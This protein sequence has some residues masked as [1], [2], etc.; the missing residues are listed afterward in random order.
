MCA[1][2][3]PEGQPLEDFRLRLP[4]FSEFSFGYALTDNLIHGGLPKKLK[5]APTFPSL[6]KEGK[7]GGGYDVKVPLISAPL[8]LQFK[9]P[10]ILTRKSNKTPPG[11]GMPYYRMHVRPGGQSLQHQNLLNH[12][13]RHRLVY[14]VT[15]RFHNK[16]FLRRRMIEKSAFIRPSQIGSLDDRDHFVAYDRRHTVAWLYSEPHE[17]EG[18]IDS[19]TFIE[20]VEANIPEVR[21]AESESDLFESIAQEIIK[22]YEISVRET[23][24]RAR[25]EPSQ[26]RDSLSPTWQIGYD[27]PIEQIVGA[28]RDEAINQFVLAR[29]RYGSSGAAAYMAR[30]YLDCELI[31]VGKNY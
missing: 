25:D 22:T 19:E 13:R 20:E 30:F 1:D 3:G 24:A 18:S 16:V 8:F 5:A 6:Y 4:Q 7:P 14:Y 17:V 10:Q 11:F 23:E 31:I 29:E 15:P 2:W 28:A 21:R 27:Q 9:I 26:R 12:E